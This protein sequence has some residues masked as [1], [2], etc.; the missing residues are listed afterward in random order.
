MAKIYQ[1]VQ[2]GGDRTVMVGSTPYY[3]TELFGTVQSDIF[4][5]DTNTNLGQITD[6]H[7]SG[8]EVCYKAVSGGTTTI[9]RL[10]E[11]T[12]SSATFMSVKTEGNSYKVYI[13]KFNNG[14]WGTPTNMTV[15]SGTES[16]FQVAASQDNLDSRKLWVD[17]SNGYAILKYY[18]S[19]SM[20]WK[21]TNG[22]WA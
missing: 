21:P 2:S 7:N 17:I 12:S 14:A 8:K 11:L 4:W 20:T 22:M 13:L 5:A 19:S 15:A 18:D 16:M 3:F 9:Y 1:R 10:S 6:A